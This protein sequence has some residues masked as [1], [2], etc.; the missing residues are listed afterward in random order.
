VNPYLIVLADDHVLVR[1]GLKTIIE[2]AADLKVVGEASDGLKLLELLKKLTPNM[3]I[4]DI[5]MPNLRGIETTKEIK[6]LYPEVK[7]L[8]LTMHKEKELLDQ[9]LSAGIDGYLVKEDAYTELLSAIETIRQGK[10]YIS[11]LL[12]QEFKNLIFQ[13]YRGKQ[14]SSSLDGLTTREVEII[15]LIAEG[16]SSREIGHF[17]RVSTRTVEK[18]RSNIMKKLHIN[19][20]IDLVKYALSKGFTSPN[21]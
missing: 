2:Q 13:R 6:K 15:K 5:E 19:K 20:S 12:A 18:H 10:S 17:L 1:Q 9:A 7:V 16:K 21:A 8:I 14:S 4:L 11:P 3:A